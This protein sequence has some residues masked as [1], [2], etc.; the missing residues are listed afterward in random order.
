M[1]RS[2]AF[3]CLSICAVVVLMLALSVPQRG[4]RAACGIAVPCPPPGGGSSGGSADTGEKEKHKKPTATDVPPTDT[5]TATPTGTPTATP[6]ETSTATPS[7]TALACA[8][9]A[10]AAANPPD[11]N[12]Q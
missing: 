6:T 7:A 11:P 1:K 8:K 5:P 4:A 3:W 9:P 10:V 2:G 12:P